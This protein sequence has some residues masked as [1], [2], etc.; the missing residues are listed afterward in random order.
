MLERVKYYLAT[1]L[2][3]IMTGLTPGCGKIQ[4]TADSQEE[5]TIPE[6]PGCPPVKPVNPVDPEPTNQV[7]LAANKAGPKIIA[8]A[9]SLN[10]N[11]NW[12]SGNVLYEIFQLIREYDHEIHNGV[13]DGSNWYKAIFE[14]SQAVDDAYSRCKEVPAQDTESPFDF[15]DEGLKHSYNCS[16]ERESVSG[17][18][19]YLRSAM[20]NQAGDPFVVEGLIAQTI[21]QTSQVSS[22]AVQVDIDPETGDLILAQAYLVD[23]EG[24]NDYAVRSYIK[25]NTNSGLFSL[26]MTK[27]S[28]GGMS[29]GLSISAAGYASGD[30][31]YLIKVLTSN[32]DA[33]SSGYYCLKSLTTEAEMQ[34]MEPIGSDTIPETCQEFEELMPKSD[35]RE[36]GSVLAKE[37]VF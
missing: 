19:T 14:A 24:E 30:N 16:Q 9:N 26:K 25:S 8:T 37:K 3:L 4:E 10:L 11:D 18:T 22:S 23:Y 13:I 28:G 27:G 2:L 1:V 21:I 17:N 29:G 6:H 36:D 32:H 35:Y 12:E 34:L 15:E 20:V 31:H 5:K 7:F 33:A